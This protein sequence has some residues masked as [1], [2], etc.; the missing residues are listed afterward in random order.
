[1]LT[2]LICC[3]V[4][5]QEDEGDS[6]LR[7]SA[8]TAVTAEVIDFIDV[9]TLA[10]IQVGQVQPSQEMVVLDPRQDAGAGLLMLRGR[11]GGSVRI[12]YTQQVQMRNLETN[13]IL[14]VDYAISGNMLNDQAASKLLTTNPE[15]IVLSDDGEYYVWIGCSFS[16]NDV[17]P[18]QYDGDFVVEVEYP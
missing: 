6:F 10:D 1:M 12:A 13:S 17:Q 15:L 14:T 4:F 5:S 9:V 8:T 2:A 18:G 11:A 3:S 7:A 16:L